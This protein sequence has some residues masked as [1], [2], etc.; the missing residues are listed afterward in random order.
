M[1][2]MTIEE[3]VAIMSEFHPAGVRAMAPAFAEADLRDVLP[4]INVPTLLLYGD[5]DRRSPLN[6]AEEFHARIP[7]SRLVVMHGVGHAS[8]V[9][10][11]ERFN[12]EVR[13]FLRSMQS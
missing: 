7:T 9:E 3:V 6:V 11:A 5:A 10:A 2:L 13:S 12:T 4:R 8:N 1:G